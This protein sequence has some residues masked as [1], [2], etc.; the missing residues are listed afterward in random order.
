MDRMNGRDLVPLLDQ[1]PYISLVRRMAPAAAWPARC[2]HFQKKGWFLG[3]VNA[4]YH[5]ATK[6]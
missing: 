4:G 5:L 6:R 3:E 1:H 2:M